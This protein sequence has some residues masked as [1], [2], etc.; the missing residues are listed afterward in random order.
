MD[1]IAYLCSGIHV[2]LCV[3]GKKKA[4]KLSDKN[5]YRNR[6]VVGFFF[7]IVKKKKKDNIKFTTL[8]TFKCTTVQ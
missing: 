6:Q 1:W 4:V 3:R 8:T 7:L 5:N 2:L